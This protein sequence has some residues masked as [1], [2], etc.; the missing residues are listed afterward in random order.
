MRRYLKKGLLGDK[1]NCLYTGLKQIH[2]GEDVWLIGQPNKT[3]SHVVIYAPD[4]KTEYHVEGYNVQ[5]L[6]N[7]DFWRG[8]YRGRNNTDEA[9][10]KIYILT[11]ILDNEINWCFDLSKIPDNGYLK[12]I[13]ENGTVKNINFEGIFEKQELISRRF[14]YNNKEHK[15]YVNPVAYRIK[16]LN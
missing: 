10:V 16:K 2:I 13:Y 6:L 5:K 9:K 3:K 15:T 14:T 8:V 11:S 1:F 7:N 4:R 12:V